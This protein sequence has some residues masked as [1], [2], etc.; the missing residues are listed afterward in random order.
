MILPEI[1]NN[2]KLLIFNQI[3]TLKELNAFSG[4]MFGVISFLSMV[5]PG[6]RVARVTLRTKHPVRRGTTP[7][8][9]VF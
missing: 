2:Y 5:S 6:S 7:S 3:K 1:K 9:L 8:N 4:T